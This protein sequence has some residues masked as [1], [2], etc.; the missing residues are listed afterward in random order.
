MELWL[1]WIANIKLCHG[2]KMK[3]QSFWFRGAN[4]HDLWWSK[5]RSKQGM[6]SRQVLC[7]QACFSR[8]TMVTLCHKWKDFLDNGLN[9][10]VVAQ[11]WVWALNYDGI[12]KQGGLQHKIMQHSI[13]ILLC[14]LHQ[15]TCNSRMDAQLHAL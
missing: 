5:I 3:Y 9:T 8:I 10:L 11:K 6:G 2:T 13:R 15:K 4:F 1:G 12:L 7:Q 14:V